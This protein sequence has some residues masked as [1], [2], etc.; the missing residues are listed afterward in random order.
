MNV[1]EQCAQNSVNTS[2]M[3]S[4]KAE[5]D[6][7]VWLHDYRPTSE[8]VKCFQ[9]EQDKRVVQTEKE[10]ERERLIERERERERQIDEAGEPQ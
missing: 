5:S 3:E 2:F 10:I 1:D 6:G 4:V 7:Y 9:V 8:S